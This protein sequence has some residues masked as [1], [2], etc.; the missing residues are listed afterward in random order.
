MRSSTQANQSTS[1]PFRLVVLAALGLSVAAPA[2][3]DLVFFRSGRSMSV[4][5]HRFEQGVLILEL[6][7]GGE[8]QCD[9]MAVERIEP[10]EIPYPDAATAATAISGEPGQGGRYGDLVLAVA[11]EEGLDPRLI[12]A[13]IRVESGYESRATSPKGAMGLMQLMP[14]TAREYGVADPYDPAA[15][16]RAGARHLKSLLDR[17]DVSVALAAYNA[18]EAAILRFGGIPP[19]RETREYVRRILSLWP[20]AGGP[21]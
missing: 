18:G 7:A 10:D 11:I 21:R 9:L 4:K 17:F 1:R 13:I 16:V 5:R 19:Y 14:G 8:V 12:H 6:R 2:S 15:N 3:A 20:G